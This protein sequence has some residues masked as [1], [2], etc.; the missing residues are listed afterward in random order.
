MERL[1]T[2][3]QY[4]GD[5][6]DAEAAER[7]GDEETGQFQKE[8]TGK[9][10][11]VRLCLWCGGMSVT[12]ACR[13]GTTDIYVTFSPCRL[14]TASPEDVEYLNCQQELM[15]DLHSQYQLVERII[16]KEIH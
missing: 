14:K 2:H 8:G 1:V 10:K 4:L 3:S 15:D 11:V 6:G 9:E 16:S 5:G 13:G 12:S 7:E